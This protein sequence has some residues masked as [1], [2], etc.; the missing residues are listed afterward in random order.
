MQRT[1]QGVAVIS[2]DTKNSQ[3]YVDALTV[4]KKPTLMG[5]EIVGAPFHLNNFGA[6]HEK[7]IA[8]DPGVYRVFVEF[9]AIE[10][11]IGGRYSFDYEVNGASTYPGN[12]NVDTSPDPNQVK[13]DKKDF[14][15]IVLANGGA[16]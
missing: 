6:G 15:L 11:K 3:A 8:L 9:T 7:Q 2:F 16:Q 13:D 12:G 5:Y 1:I 14:L 10:N 4:I